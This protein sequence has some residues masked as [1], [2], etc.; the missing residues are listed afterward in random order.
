MLTH[1]RTRKGLN[2]NLTQLNPNRSDK[3]S[4]NSQKI[5]ILD[6]PGWIHILKTKPVCIMLLG[7]WLNPQVEM[8]FDSDFI[9]NP[10]HNLTRTLPLNLTQ[11]N[12]CFAFLAR[13]NPSGSRL[14]SQRSRLHSTS[15][16]RGLSDI[17]STPLMLLFTF[18][19]P[20]LT[21]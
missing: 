7:Y 3:K 10:C 1:T 19:V 16:Y 6:T 15:L 11:F 13:S 4:K 20:N 18:V 8:Q 12:P 14:S 17:T 5:M 2:P 21:I 9:P